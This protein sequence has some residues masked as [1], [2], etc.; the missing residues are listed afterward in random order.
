MSAPRSALVTGGAGFIGSHLADH[1]IEGGYAVT[2]LDNLATGRAAD[3]PDGATFVEGDVRN[4]EDVDRAFAG[5]IDV[6]CHLAGQASIRRAWDDP[7]ADLS[8]NVLGT[9]NII[10]GCRRHHTNRLLYA[11]SMT[12]Y[13]NPTAIPTPEGADIAP[14]SCYGIT[15][16]AGERY[17]M[18]AGAEGDPRLDVT[19]FRMFNV[20]GPRQSLTNPYQGVLAIFLGNVL[21]GEPVCIHSDG[22][23]SRDFVF[24]GDVC[25]AWCDAIDTPGA[26][27]RV[28]NLG[29]GRDTSVNALCDAVLARV[30][31]TRQSYDI[32]SAPAQP[33]DIRR[34]V[35]DVSDIGRTLGWAPQVDLD[36]GMSETVRWAQTAVEEQAG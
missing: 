10:A 31:A 7:G 30:G 35:A 23:Q 17:V 4:P 8:V 36:R 19:A 14:V 6:V 12:V 9:L 24:V 22:E 34:S 21:R 15:K 3:V 27:G 25:R 2:V 11:S 28:F 29:S 20:Y 16:Y 5:G 13:G 1:L 18:L 32:S 33:G 26:I